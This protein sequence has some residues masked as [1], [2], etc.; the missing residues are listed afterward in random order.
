M[1]NVLVTGSDGFIG[2]NLLVELKRI[3][4]LKIIR[5]TRRDTLETLKASLKEADIVY[6]L[7]GANRPQRLEEYQSDNF[8][9]TQ[10]ILELLK[11]AHHFPPIV[12]TSSIQAELENPYGRSKQQAETSLMAY[13]RETGASVFI[14]RLPNIFGKWAK[15]NYNSVVATFC[16]NIAHDLEITISDPNKELEL[17]YIDDLVEEFVSLLNSPP[18]IPSMISSPLPGHNRS[19]QISIFRTVQRSFRV[20]LGTIAEKIHQ[21]RDIRRTSMVPDLSDELMK[22]LYATYLSYVEPNGF[23][24]PLEMHKDSRGYLVELLKSPHFGQ[25]F[26]SRSHDG[27]LRGNHYHNTK[28][29]KFLVLEGKA[30]VRLRNLLSQDVLS[31]AVSGDNIEIVDI[32]PGYTHSI[33]NLS[34]DELIVLFWASEVFDPNHPDT[35]YLDV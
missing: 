8:D 23:S 22:R 27:V 16:S 15:P 11:S 10:T 14:Y 30:L 35:H 19:P 18:Q 34:S 5:F 13:Q 7:A 29:E 28:V 12:F 21:I 3:N 2:K 9:L 6:H 31:Y 33:E 24:Y 1:K 26:L 17:V 4:G 25:I 32:P 20:S